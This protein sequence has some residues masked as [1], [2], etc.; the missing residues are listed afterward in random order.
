MNNKSDARARV[1]AALLQSKFFEERIAHLNLDH[2]IDALA[3]LA[4]FAVER[5]EGAETRLHEDKRGFMDAVIR[6]WHI[7][8]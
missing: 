4:I 6:D 3:N 2:Q 7:D 5:L 8:Q 1:F